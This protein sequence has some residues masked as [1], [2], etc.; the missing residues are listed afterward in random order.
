MVAL[1]K[2]AS[3]AV[4]D[5]FYLRS[6]PLLLTLE[7]SGHGVPWLVIPA[8]I[9]LLAPSLSPPASG[10]ILNYLALAAVDLAAIGI[11]KPCVARARPAHNAG[12]AAVTIEAIDQYS[13]PS[14]HATRAGLNAT[15]VAALQADFPDKVAGIWKSKAFLAAV[16]VWAVAVAVS[17][18]ALGRHHVVD[19]VV[20][21]AMGV[22]YVAVWRYCWIADEAADGLRNS[23]RHAVFG[24]SK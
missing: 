8:L 1:D 10:W 5:A 11:V 16:V 18:V 23:L 24:A 4:Y 19:V 21:L 14:G 17:R 7:L 15:F 3:R 2:R 13:F 12:L 9:F 6:R 22:L 20:G